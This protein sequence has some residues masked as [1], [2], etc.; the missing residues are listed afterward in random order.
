MP[1]FQYNMLS[2]LVSGNYFYQTGAYLNDITRIFTLNNFATPSSPAILCSPADIPIQEI[3]AYPHLAGLEIPSNSF[4]GEYVDLTSN[5]MKTFNYYIEKKTDSVHGGLVQ[6]CAKFEGQQMP[7]KFLTA[8]E[9]YEYV[10]SNAG[11]L[12]K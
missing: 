2:V 11:Q 7:E 12:E 8:D 1:D 6:S 4:N 9:V 10:R 3:T 5:V